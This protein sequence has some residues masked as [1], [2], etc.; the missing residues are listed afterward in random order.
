MPAPA[1][2]P[3]RNRRRL[4]ADLAFFTVSLPG[5]IWQRRGLSPR[6]LVHAGARSGLLTRPRV[7]GPC[8]SEDAPPARRSLLPYRVG[9]ST[10]QCMHT[11]QGEHAPTQ[12]ADFGQ[13]P[14]KKSCVWPQLRRIGLSPARAPPPTSAC[15]TATDF[16]TAWT[17]M[18]GPSCSACA[19][20]RVI[21]AKRNSPPQSSRTSTPGPCPSCSATTAP[22]RM[23]SADSPSGRARDRITSCAAIRT[24]TAVPAAAATRGSHSG[25]AAVSSRVS[26]SASCAGDPRRQDSA[27]HRAGPAAGA[28]S[29]SDSTSA[30]GPSAHHPPRLHHHDAWSP[31][32]PLRARNG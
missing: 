15:A 19:E 27:P 29:G 16:N 18:P 1:A 21:R 11:T 13:R 25:P 9:L 32:A 10:M 22:G 2:D 12:Q 20:R 24:R 6:F 7:T 30:A 23:F 8:Q 28:V 26:P 14:A 4:K 3:C 31:A 5:F 17:A